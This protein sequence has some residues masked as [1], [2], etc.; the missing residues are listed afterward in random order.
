MA[1]LHSLDLA[2]DWG[3]LAAQNIATYRGTLYARAYLSGY[4]DA[5]RAAE[6]DPRTAAM[7]AAD[8]SARIGAE[9][10]DTR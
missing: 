3:Y 8:S 9:A 1:N 5:L 7:G 4:A 6:R 10:L 2:R